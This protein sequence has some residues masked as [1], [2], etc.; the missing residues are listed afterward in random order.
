MMSLVT[1]SQHELK[2]QGKQITMFSLLSGILPP[3]L[4]QVAQA[5]LLMLAFPRVRVSASETKLL[6][7]YTDFTFEG[8]GQ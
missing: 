1:T 6:Q 7:Q 5:T 8:S 3:M 2:E 4:F